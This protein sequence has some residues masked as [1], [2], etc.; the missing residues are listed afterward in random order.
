MFPEHTALLKP[1]RVKG[2]IS[3]ESGRHCA[4]SFTQQERATL[5]KIPILIVFADHL[6]DVPAFAAQ[7]SQAITQCRQFAEVLQKEGDDVTFLHLPEIGIHGS[8]RLLMLDKNNLQIAD[9]SLSW[10]SSRVEHARPSV[11]KDSP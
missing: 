1:A 8:T 6:T 9:L 7:W 2:I 3:L 10:I 4:E 11:V 5:A